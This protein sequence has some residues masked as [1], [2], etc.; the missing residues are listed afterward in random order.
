MQFLIVEGE[1]KAVKSLFSEAPIELPDFQQTTYPVEVSRVRRISNPPTSRLF[2]PVG[3]ATDS[4]KVGLGAGFRLPLAGVWTLGFGMQTSGTLT[5][6]KRYRITDY[7]AGDDFVNVGAGSN[8]TG[9]FFTASG[10]TPT[11]WT[12]GSTL[13]EITSDLDFD[14][15]AAELET[16]L[17]ALT[18]ITAAGGVTVTETATGLFAVV[19]DDAGAREEMQGFSDNLAPDSVID[20]GTV[21]NGSSLLREIQTVRV[22]QDP[23]AL[24]TLDGSITESTGSVTEVTAG[25]GGNNHKV[26]VVLTPAPYGGS[27]TLTVRS[28]ESALLSFDASAADIVTALENLALTSGL[29]VTGAKYKI[30]TFVAGDNFTNVGAGSNATGVVFV[31]SGTTPTTWTNGSTLSPVGEGN[32]EVVQESSHQWLISF[33]GNMANTAM[34]TIAIDDSGLLSIAGRS[35]TLDARTAAAELL[36]GADDTVS[37]YLEIE[38]TP[39]G[40]TPTRWLKR[41]AT[42]VGPVIPPASEDTI[43]PGG[44]YDTVTGAG[45]Y[46]ITI[47]NGVIS[48]DNF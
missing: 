1:N 46:R 2:E 47:V 34:A 11:T 38:V 4:I 29:L 36:L 19:F 40:G 22:T 13:V 35:G 16:A 27:F 7:N 15:T 31:A 3:A 44:I 20:A 5:T 8:A 17:N 30:I 14:N 37:L 10:T 21:V 25:G 42:L 18:S 12:N 48:Y 24:K 23:V 6:G 32:V 33:I 9:Q 26:R 43:P 41:S 39:S 28:V 45:P